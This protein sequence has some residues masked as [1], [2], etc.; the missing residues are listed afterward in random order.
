MVSPTTETLQLKKPA[1]GYGQKAE[2]FFVTLHHQ[3]CLQFTAT[4]TGT[5][6]SRAACQCSQLCRE[7]CESHILITTMLNAC[8]Q[9]FTQEGKMHNH[10]SRRMEQYHGNLKKCE[11]YDRGERQKSLCLTLQF[12]SPGGPTVLCFLL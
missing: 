7:D 12:P 10:R 8:L 6:R 1:S 11:P 3:Y 5:W 2:L 4:D 9:Y